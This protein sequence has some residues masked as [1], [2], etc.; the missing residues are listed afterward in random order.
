LRL[1]LDRRLCADRPYAVK[2]MFT[3]ERVARVSEGQG[4]HRRNGFAAGIAALGAVLCGT[5]LALALDGGAFSYR[6]FPEPPTPK[7]VDRGAG[8]AP[9][10]LGR[11]RDLSFA[12]GRPRTRVSSG[13]VERLVP[14][15]RLRARG[16]A[17][18]RAP[19][20]GGGPGGRRGAQAFSPSVGRGE[21]Y[22]RRAQERVP[23][24]FPPDGNGKG[25]RPVR[26]TPRPVPGPLRRPGPPNP[27]SPGPTLRPVTVPPRDSTPA[28]SDH[29]ARPGPREVTPGEEPLQ[30]PSGEGE[31][32]TQA[33]G[34]MGTS[35][36]EEH[37]EPKPVARRPLDESAGPRYRRA[38]DR[39]QHG[40]SGS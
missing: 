31:G 23:R 21:A 19:R 13:S 27:P 20:S 8:G 2:W 24:A 18:G 6:D 25:P 4:M 14:L 17:G 33:G 11:K 30:V 28:G 26:E 5:V 32:S 34:D 40:A 39:A 16:P 38:D 36:A 9:S 1:V 12:G 10:A 29:P 35:G 37:P 7:L 3:G 15:R 22:R